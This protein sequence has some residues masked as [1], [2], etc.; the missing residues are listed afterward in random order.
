MCSAF[1]VGPQEDGC[2]LLKREPDQPLLSPW[3]KR[4][5]GGTGKGPQRSCV[6][7]YCGARQ[8]SQFVQA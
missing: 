5:E 8:G 7:R 6:T 1:R 4:N 2:N 3:I